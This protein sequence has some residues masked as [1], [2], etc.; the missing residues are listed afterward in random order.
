MARVSTYLGSSRIVSRARFAEESPTC[1]MP[2][3]GCGSANEPS[4]AEEK[5][6]AFAPT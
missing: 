4:R 5:T 1:G 3:N 6:C 2:M